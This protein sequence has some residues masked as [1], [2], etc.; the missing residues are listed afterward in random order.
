MKCVSSSFSNF[1]V[2]KGNTENKN[3]WDMKI[4]HDALLYQEAFPKT[5]KFTIFVIEFS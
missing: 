2:L 3:G 5:V 1:S 4:L